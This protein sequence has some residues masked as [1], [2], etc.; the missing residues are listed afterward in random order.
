MAAE[1]NSSFGDLVR[2]SFS[3]ESEAAQEDFALLGTFGPPLSRQEAWSQNALTMAN[4]ERVQAT[5]TQQ[6]DGN[7]NHGALASRESHNRRAVKTPKKEAQK[8]DKS[9]D[10]AEEQENRRSK[11]ERVSSSEDSEIPKPRKKK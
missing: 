3:S 2:A 11:K 10:E 6:P 5:D 8:P 9:S 4:V 7:G 1:F